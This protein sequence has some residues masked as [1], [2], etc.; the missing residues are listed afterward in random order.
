ME[1]GGKGEEEKKREE[2]WI[3]RRK[4]GGG[5]KKYGMGEENKSLK[6][7]REGIRV[8]YGMERECWNLR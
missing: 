2:R 4:G 3:K 6:G 5:Q 8:E 7:K 1:N